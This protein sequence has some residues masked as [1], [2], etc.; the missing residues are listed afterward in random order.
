VTEPIKVTNSRDLV[1]VQTIADESCRRWLM[2]DPLGKAAVEEV[3]NLLSTI[4]YLNTGLDLFNEDVREKE[5]EVDD[6]VLV[7][8][9]DDTRK[10]VAH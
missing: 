3:Y 6:P 9:L 10:T 8:T 7:P 2:A 1:Q 5:F 4:C